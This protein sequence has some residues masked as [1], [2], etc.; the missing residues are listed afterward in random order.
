[1]VPR[2]WKDGWK[3]ALPR[4]AKRCYSSAR[5]RDD[6]ERSCNEQCKGDLTMPTVSRRNTFRLLGSLALVPAALRGAMAQE[7]WPVVAGI[8]RRWPIGRFNT[9]SFHGLA[10]G[11]SAVVGGVKVRMRI[12]PGD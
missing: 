10:H 9:G 2:G 4:F 5:E 1:M 6:T 11:G 8:A 7:K 3:D 12:E